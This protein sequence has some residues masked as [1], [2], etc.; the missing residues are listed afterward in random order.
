MPLVTRELGPEGALVDVSID[1]HTARRRQLEKHGF[2]VPASVSIKAQLDTG[3]HRSGIYRNVF[4]ALGLSGEIDYENVRTS[5][6]QDEPHVADVYVCNLT[7]H[8]AEGERTFQTLRVLAHVFG[9]DEEARAVI[10]RD[11]LA[12]CLLTWDGPSRRFTLCF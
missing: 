8:G 7:I 1:V 11:V 4:P 5:S 2:S 10:G 12:Q 9:P 6:T 3:A